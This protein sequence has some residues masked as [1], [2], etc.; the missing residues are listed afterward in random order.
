MRTRTIR[1]IGGEVWAE[2]TYELWRRRDR[3]DVSIECLSGA[4]M[5]V[6]TEVV[7]GVLARY[8]GATV[9]NDPDL[10]VKPLPRKPGDYDGS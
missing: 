9:Q 2:L 7:M 4:G 10:P 8:S 1:E 6:V 5:E 3:G